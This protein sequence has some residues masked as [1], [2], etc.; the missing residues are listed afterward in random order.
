MFKQPLRSKL[1]LDRR[2]IE[3][4]DLFLVQAFYG[5][6]TF[7]IKSDFEDFEPDFSSFLVPGRFV[8]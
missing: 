1:K 8:D 4:L 7:T 3:R 6:V 2:V 5:A